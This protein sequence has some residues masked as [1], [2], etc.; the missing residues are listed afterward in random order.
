[1][2]F[3]RKWKLDEVDVEHPHRTFRQEFEDSFDNTDWAY[4]NTMLKM[5]ATARPWWPL[6]TADSGPTLRRKCWRSLCD[7]LSDFVIFTKLVWFQPLELDLRVTVFVLLFVFLPLLVD[8]L[9]S[10]ET[11]TTGWGQMANPAWRCSHS[12]RSGETNFRHPGVRVSMVTSSPAEG[13]GND[14]PDN[15]HNGGECASHN[16]LLE[17]GEL[18]CVF[19]YAVHLDLG[20]CPDTQGYLGHLSGPHTPSHTL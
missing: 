16:V 11:S 8:R 9:W 20:Y 7:N 1:M 10:Q 6:V 15:P 2:R 13:V 12:F 5:M 18:P 3:V 14:Q 17:Y 4:N 19:P